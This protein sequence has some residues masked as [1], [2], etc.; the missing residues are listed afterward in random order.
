VT[1][2]IYVAIIAV[3][4]VVLVPAWLR[5][6]DHLDPE[7]SVDR[8]TRSMQT[9]AARP[10][11][12]GI[13]MPTHEE[14]ADAI[15]APTAEVVRPRRGMRPRR[16]LRRRPKST[17]SPANAQTSTS[18]RSS[19]AAKGRG[20]RR[21][22][23]AARRRIVLAVLTVALLVVIGLVV[24]GVL[25]PV[26]IAAPSVLIVGFLFLARHQVRAARR[27]RRRVER[28]GAPSAA[29]TSPAARPAAPAS[30][31][32]GATWEARATPLPTYVTAPRADGYPRSA[33]PVP[34]AWTAAAMLERAQRQK[35]HAERMAAAKAEAVARARAEQAAAQTPTRDEQFLAA[36]SASP[37]HDTI[38]LRRMRVVNE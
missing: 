11:V 38:P 16:G 33:D 35:D 27:A 19:G 25:L 30:G 24:A 10:S 6:H 21:L 1:G 22:S 26:A 18:R 36:Q 29:A 12:L 3:W 2:L 8:F 34:G 7:R 28:P 14:N 32:A 37:I 5:R 15:D 17:K 13:P 31:T 9:L 20:R 23:A 4:A